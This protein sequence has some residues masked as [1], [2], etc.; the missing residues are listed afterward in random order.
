MKREKRERLA[1][2]LEEADSNLQ[3]AKENLTG[4]PAMQEAIVAIEEELDL[5]LEALNL[6]I[7]TE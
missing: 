5:V 6:D 3:T 2:R 4:N 7:T 1:S